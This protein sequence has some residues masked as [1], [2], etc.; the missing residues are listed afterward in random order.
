M[1]NTVGEKWLAAGGK[2]AVEIGMGDAAAG[3]PHTV[4]VEGR[5]DGAGAWV[6]VPDGKIGSADGW[7]GGAVGFRCAVVAR[8]VEGRCWMGAAGT[9]V[10]GGAVWMASVTGEGAVA[11]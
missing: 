10:A 11:R 8:W 6:G 3:E 5:M 9:K 2:G 4:G 1:R 7:F